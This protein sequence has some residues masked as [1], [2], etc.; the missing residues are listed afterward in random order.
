[1]S[2]GV[3]ALSAGS[4]TAAPA[5]LPGNTGEPTISGRVE[6]GRTLSSS[7]GSWAGTQPISFARQWLRCGADGGRP[8]GGDC[9]IISGAAGRTYRLTSAD[10][11]ARLR[12]RVTASNA[13]GSQTVASNPTSPVVGP[14][15]NTSLPIVRGTALVGSVLTADPGSWRGRQG[16]SYSYSWLRCN[17]Q[18]GE[19]VA[20]GATGRN[21]RLTSSDVGHKLRFNLT[22]RNSLG[23]V[24]VMSSESGVVGEPLPSGAIRLPNGEI[25]IPA[26]SVPADRRLVV[27]QVV[28]SPDPITNRRKAFTVRVRVKDSR[29][30]VVRDAFVAVRSTPRVTTGGD[31]QA[32]TTDG[33]VT[34][35]L[36]PNGNFPQPRRGYHVHFFVKAYRA[37]DPA[38]AGVAGYRLVRVRLG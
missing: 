32:T 13:E 20:I 23:S 7:T 25:S 26:S 27:W 38:L 24:T 33:W 5:A 14:P 22:A 17:N 8:D 3:L 10:V 15:V 31:R 4:S 37:G 28:F 16:I 19:C 30:Y 1:V 6:Q 21:Y 35:Q 36:A 34:Y 18:G 9:S 2:L 12:V 11:D 29:G